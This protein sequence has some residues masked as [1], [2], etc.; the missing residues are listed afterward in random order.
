MR[1]RRLYPLA[2]H[3][4]AYVWLTGGVGATAA[5]AQVTPQVSPTVTGPNCAVYDLLSPEM[6]RAV[7]EAEKHQGHAR[8]T[9]LATSP[10]G[11]AGQKTGASV[12]AEVFHPS[13]DAFRHCV[14][15]LKGELDKVQ[16]SPIEAVQLSLSKKSGQTPSQQP[17]PAAA[18]KA[19]STPNDAVQ[20]SAPPG[21]ARSNVAAVPAAVDLEKAEAEVHELLLRHY[22][23]YRRIKRWIGW[24][25]DE[26]SIPAPTMAGM[27]DEY[28]QLASKLEALLTSHKIG[29][30]FSAELVTAFLAQATGGQS[31]ANSP[32]PPGQAAAT[33]TTQ[34][35]AAGSPAFSG[36]GFVR[37]QSIHFFADPF[38]RYDLSFAGHFGFDQA[39]APVQAGADASTQVLAVF[40]PAFVWQVDLEHNLHVA[41]TA[42][43]SFFGG[44]GQTILNATETLVA[45]GGDATV[46][47]AA[48]NG[49]GQAELFGEAGAAL[50]IYGQSLEILHLNKGLLTPRLAFKA[51]IKKDDR[52]TRSGT[53]AAFSWPEMRTFFRVSLDALQVV[54]HTQSDQ[55]FTVGV[56]V[57]FDR[58][59]RHSG[60]LVPSSTRVLLTGKLNLFKATQSGK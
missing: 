24:F 23:A 54:D 30:P 36:A 22:L 59:Y 20:P 10:V 34:Q 25:G 42:E 16:A 18:A 21:D 32:A 53:L 17:A 27:H 26:P 38:R 31:Q 47:V 8:R 51:G 13:I 56:S 14:N 46:A 35:K 4:A 48:A 40:Q 29:Q 45:N 1:C 39:F 43:L 5:F 6:A 58:A 41:D 3:V 49:T 12:D 33:A 57:D 7:G 50:N 37:W 60:K 44:L 55:T 9:R 52:F 19:A 15:L 2:R 28:G 11:G